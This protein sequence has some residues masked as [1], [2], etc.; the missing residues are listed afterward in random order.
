MITN[1][2]NTIA[3]EP[4]AR[5]SMPSVR[6]TAFENPYTKNTATA[7]HTTP[8]MWRST[9][10]VNDRSVETFT[11]FSASSAKPVA[12]MGCPPV[13]PRLRRPRLRPRRTPR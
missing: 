10:R 12:T 1:A 4:A 6:F 5:P 7:N 8:A 11:Q 9:E 3:A 13:L 2:P